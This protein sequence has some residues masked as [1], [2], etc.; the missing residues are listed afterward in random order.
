MPSERPPGD[1]LLEARGVR[2]SLGGDVVLH[3]VDLAVRSGSIHAL[4]GMNGA[5][6][7][8]LMRILLGMLSADGGT[9]SLFGI[10]VASLPSARWREVGQMIET[11]A[12]YPEL[13]A[14][15][16]ITAAALLHGLDRAAVPDSVRRAAEDLGLEQ[17]LDRRGKR[18]SLG[19]RQ[20]VAL[21]SALVHR[22][23]VLVLD[24]PS[25]SLDPSA[26][27]RLREVITGVAQRG[28]AVLVSSHHLDELARLADTVT[29]LHRGQVVGGLDPRGIDLERA[30]FD[31][32]YQAD[33]DLPGEAE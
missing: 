29:V 28:G 5:G 18:L 27:V 19:T 33:Q 21:A 8:T 2:R 4:V 26:V 6:K 11:P 15:E 24:E 10:P 3:G 16:N 13:T 12:I 9:A 14:R 32:I 30:F 23:T 17:W 1:V 22:P 25:N 20:K 7:T 31:L